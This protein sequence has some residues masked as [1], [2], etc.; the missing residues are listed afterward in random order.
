M[1]GKNVSPKLADILWRRP[2]AGGPV[3]QVGQCALD[4]LQDGATVPGDDGLPQGCAVRMVVRVSR[5]R[6]VEHHTPQ[7]VGVAVQELHIGQLFRFG[8][9]Q[10]RVIE[11]RKQDQRFPWRQR[12]A[13][14]ADD[15]TRLQLWA[16]WNKRRFLTASACKWSRRSIASPSAGD[17]WPEVAP[18]MAIGGPPSREVAQPLPEILPVVAPYR[19]IQ[20]R[21]RHL[22]DAGFETGAAFRRVEA[23]AFRLPCPQ[24]LGKRASHCEHVCDCSRSCG[25]DQIIRIMPV[26]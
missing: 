7:H 12:A 8:F 16:Q 15:G 6:Y 11:C 18:R 26:G 17:A 14:A 3:S 5:C 21:I 13:P 25:A 24:Y 20:D 19:F 4:P 23:T 1:Q 22:V 10:P 9:E 2:L